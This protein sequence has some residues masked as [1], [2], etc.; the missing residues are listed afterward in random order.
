MAPVTLFSRDL[1]AS[2]NVEPIAAP[3]NVFAEAPKVKLQRTGQR[4]LM[5][6]GVEVCS[7][8]T[9]SPGPSL[10]YEINLYRKQ[11][12]SLVIDI[13]FF[14][15]PNDMKDRF[16]TFFADSLEEVAQILESYDPALD[17]NA[18]VPVNDESV[19]VSVIALHAAVI[20]M[21]LDEARRQFADLTGEILHQ[22]DVQ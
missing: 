16:R 7:A 12:G 18:D 11:A 17:I 2:D 5:F 3:H 4:P 14:G 1:S 10:W 13:R 22:L 15:K 20:R 8:T 6:E 21:R 9:H 19:P